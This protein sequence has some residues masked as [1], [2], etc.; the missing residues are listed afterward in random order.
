[1][2][3]IK[4]RRDAEELDRRINEDL[5]ID[6]KKYRSEDTV[7][8]FVSLLLFPRY[9]ITWMARPVAIAFALYIAGFFLI[10]LVHIEYF[11]YAIIGLA[12][13]LINGLLLGFLYL[14]WKMEEDIWGIVQYSFDVLRSVVEDVSRLSDKTNKKNIRETL[15]MLFIGVIHIVTLPVV[16]KVVKRK[17]PLVHGVINWII[18]K[19]L[20]TISRRVE[21]EK[22]EEL[23]EEE[24]VEIVNDAEEGSKLLQRSVSIIEYTAAKV[25]AVIKFSFK[26]GA[27]PVKVVFGITM[28]FLLLFIYLIY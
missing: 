14:S 24:I 22:P 20:V 1:M 16:R 17:I 5:G 25:A 10:D 26:A 15:S 23:K 27:F 12:L 11:L 7:D 3:K 2:I 8:A 18:T 6:L 4:S 9:V 28:F 19:I 13:F 21:F